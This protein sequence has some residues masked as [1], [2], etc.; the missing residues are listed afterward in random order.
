MLM[1]ACLLIG[2][3]LLKQTSDQTTYL[4]CQPMKTFS[5][6]LQVNLVLKYETIQKVNFTEQVS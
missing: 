2:T 3:I 6:T 4:H 1:F 5:L